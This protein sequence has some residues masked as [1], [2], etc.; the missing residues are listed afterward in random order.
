MKVLGGKSS[1][2]K[3][4]SSGIASSVNL[5]KLL[6][7]IQRQGIQKTLEDLNIDYKNKS[8]EQLFSEMVNII[9][10][11]SNS[12]ENIVARNA[13]IKALA[14]LYEFVERNEMDISSLDKMDDILVDEVM[15]IH[16][17][18]Y[19]LE[20]LLNDL[21]SRFEK[22]SS[23][24]ETALL[25]EKECKEYIHSVVSVKLKSMKLSKLNYND[26]SIREVIKDIYSDCYSVLEGE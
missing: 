26:K 19:I 15:I 9:S 5:G 25:K 16:I 21:Q 14:E 3:Q 8:A 24:P 20:K 13:T 1:A 4:S 23:D 17:S 18:S 6:S 11:N 7:D 2:T 12:K 10:F 22:F